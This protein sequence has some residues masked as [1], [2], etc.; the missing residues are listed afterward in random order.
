MKARGYAGS[1]TRVRAWVQP[2]RAAR[3]VQDTVRFKTEPGQQS[4]VD[5]GHSGLIQHQGR[6]QRL[7]AFVMT[8]GWSRTMYLEF[9]TS[10]DETAFVRCHP[11]A[12]RYFGGIPREIVHDNLRTAVLGRGGTGAIHWNPRYLDLAHGYGFSPRACQPYR[13]QTKGKVESGVR[14]VRGNFWAGLSYR[15]LAD[16]NA[17][18]QVWMDTV[19]NVRVHGTTHEIPL[20]RLALEGLQPFAEQLNFDTSRLSYRRSG[21][22]GLVSYAGNYYSVP[23][24]DVCEQLLV[25]ETVVEELLICSLQGEDIAH[26]HLSSGRSQHIV[27]PERYAGLRP[28]SS[29]PQRAKATQIVPVS[30]SLEEW[31]QAPLVEVRPL[32][33][34][35]ELLEPVR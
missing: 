21:R 2:L 3:Q 34:Y 8:L 30:S 7:C 22:D 4:Q 15:D 1:E 33:S 32:S 11:N 29:G 20:A 16:L 9:T 24:A 13:A 18:A 17:Q 28:T 31:L 27:R 35:E 10:M 12:W 5:W 14:Y 25:K 6:Q 23:I 19:A 26:H